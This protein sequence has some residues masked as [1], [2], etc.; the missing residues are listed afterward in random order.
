MVLYLNLIVIMATALLNL[1]LVDVF[2]QEIPCDLCLA[3]RHIPM[4]TTTTIFM[5]TLISDY[6]R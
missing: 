3:V 4:D 6:S 5:S 2:H 1:H